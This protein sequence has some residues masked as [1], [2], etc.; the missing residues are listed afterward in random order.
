[1]VKSNN[2]IGLEIEYDDN[3]LNELFEIA[4]VHYPNEIGGYLLGKY[5][6][7]KKTAII[8]KQITALEYLNSPVSFKHIVNEETKNVFVKL[9]EGEGIHYLGEWHTHPNS[10]SRYSQTD[11]K[12]LKK[13]AK[14]DI[15]NPILLIVGFDKKGIKDYSFNVFF[16]KEVYKYE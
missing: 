15:E 9:F 14:G 13:I 5:S 2:K 10:N 1:M 4:L 7:N 11:F 16:N 8:V 3:L 12:A 6:E